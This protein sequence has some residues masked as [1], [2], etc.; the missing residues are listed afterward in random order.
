MHRC[1]CL[2]CELN[3]AILCSRVDKMQIRRSRISLRKGFAP[4]A[5]LHRLLDDRRFKTMGFVFRLLRLEK[6]QISNKDTERRHRDSPGSDLI[7]TNNNVLYPMSNPFP[8]RFSKSIF[9]ERQMQL[10]ACFQKHPICH[11]NRCVL[12][13]NRLELQQ[14]FQLVLT[15][16]TSAEMS[17]KQTACIV[18]QLVDHRQ[19]KPFFNLSVF[20]CHTPLIKNTPQSF[21]H[22]LR[23]SEEMFLHR[24][25]RALHRFG[26]FP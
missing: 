21:S 26:N 8:E 6:N 1:Y 2:E 25:F 11:L 14:L 19:V 18:I 23:C 7:L 12:G 24:P 16:G 9:E 20:H 17:I 15:F 13:N 10:P 22:P 5:R 3:R 4:A